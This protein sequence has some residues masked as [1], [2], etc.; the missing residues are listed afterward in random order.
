MRNKIQIALIGIMFVVM[1]IFCNYI[2]TTYTRFVTVKDVINN[3][4][5]T[6]DANGYLWEFEEDGFHKG[7]QV[8][9]IMNNNH[10]DSIIIDDII[11]KA[12]KINK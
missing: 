3:T 8:K 9:L 1:I 11:T 12:I 5:I 7:D 6:E 10:T 4:V 2:E